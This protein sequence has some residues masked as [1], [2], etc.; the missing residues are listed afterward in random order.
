MTL[1]SL[2]YQEIYQAYSRFH[3]AVDLGDVEGYV[4]SFTENGWFEVLGLPGGAPAAGRTTGH[5]ALRKMATRLTA[6]VAGNSRHFT[7]PTSMVIEG[8][9]AAASTRGYVF[10]LRPGL[11][12]NVGV[13]LTGLFDDELVKIDD[14]WVFSSKTIRMDPQPE[15]GVPTDVL[16]RKFDQLYPRSSEIDQ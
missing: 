12:P 6:G 14:R 3:L 8:D 2:D 7:S 15:A 9:S 5:A 13:F 4:M 1:S 11:V 10:E 16:V